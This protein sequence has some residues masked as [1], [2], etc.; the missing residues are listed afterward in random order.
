M[1]G[2]RYGDGEI[3]RV[4]LEED[5]TEALLPNPRPRNRLPTSL[6]SPARRRG[7]R[8]GAS[9]MRLLLDTREVADLVEVSRTVGWFTTLF[10]TVLDLVGADEI[11]ADSTFAT[12]CGGFKKAS[13]TVS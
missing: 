4:E 9:R 8:C 2:Q 11:R 5:D 13:A 12:G 10:P 6:T 1:L 7:L 3:V